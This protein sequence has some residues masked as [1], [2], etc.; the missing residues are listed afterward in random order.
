MFEAVG[1]SLRRG[2]SVEFFHS[3]GAVFR[4]VSPLFR[5]VKIRKKQ[6]IP[7]AAPPVLLFI[8]RLRLFIGC[9]NGFGLGEFPPHLFEFLQHVIIG[10]DF[11]LAI[12]PA[13]FPVIVAQPHFRGHF[14]ADGAIVGDFIKDGI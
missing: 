4:A 2:G 8:V 10:A 14:L 7:A 11:A 6:T 12:I 9:R 5:A 13:C 3:S 1:G